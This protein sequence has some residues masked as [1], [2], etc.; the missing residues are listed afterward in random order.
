MADITARGLWIRVG[1]DLVCS[2]GERGALLDAV[3][4]AVVACPT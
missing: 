3:V 4:S 2:A 1:E